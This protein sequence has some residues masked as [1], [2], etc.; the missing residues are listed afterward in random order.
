MNGPI[1]GQLYV[2]Y[3]VRPTSFPLCF[4]MLKVIRGLSWA[5]I[6]PVINLI[7]RRVYIYVHVDKYMYTHMHAWTPI[8]ILKRFYVIKTMNQ[9]HFINVNA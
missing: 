6:N 4:Q 1:P 3:I 9:C 8:S 2:T 5:F 7:H